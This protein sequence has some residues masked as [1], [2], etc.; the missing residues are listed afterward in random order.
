MTRIGLIGAG[1]GVGAAAMRYL[2]GRGAGT[3]VVGGRTP[4]KAVALAAPAD[5]TRLEPKRVDLFDAQSLA[6]FCRDVDI[7][8]NCA[9]PSGQVADRV[10][11][12]AVEAGRP[13][14][15]VGGYDPVFHRLREQREHILAAGVPVVINAGLL[16]GLSGLHPRWLAGAYGEPPSTLD[17]FY[18]GTDRWSYVSAWDI[19]HSLGD[20]GAERPPSKVV[21]GRPVAVK[22]L[23]AFRKMEFPA[24]IGR[25]NGFLTYTEEIATLAQDLKIREANCHG[26][27]NGPISGLALAFVK[28]AGLYRTPAQID[29]SA[30][31]LVRASSYDRRRGAT[32][33]FAIDC[34][35]RWADG[36]SRHARLVVGDTY[37]ATGVAVAI[38]AWMIATGELRAKGPMM[39]HQAVD[40]AA[41]LTHFRASGCVS[42]ETVPPDLPV[43]VQPSKESVHA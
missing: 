30:R 5:R 20:F 34:R 39:L 24:P 35:A 11:M 40:P 32:P 8:V 10:V 2:L 22:W 18:V 38:T 4:E 9:G 21:D 6:S 37:K 28:L 25:A 42:E 15:D 43:A 7:V 23:K 16:P 31:W 14:V 1:G 41:F 13:A 3:I 26:T 36:N 27:N 19:I 17:V 33:C 29:R 12:A